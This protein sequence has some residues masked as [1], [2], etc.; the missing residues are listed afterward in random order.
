MYQRMMDEYRKRALSE[1][2][3]KIA[4]QCQPFVREGKL[5]IRKDGERFFFPMFGCG[6][7]EE[8]TKRFFMFTR[9]ERVKF[10]EIRIFA[11]HEQ[12]RI[13]ICHL[14]SFNRKNI[15][16]VR[17]LLLSYKDALVLDTMMFHYFHGWCNLM[18]EV[19]S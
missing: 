19:L 7:F 17:G 15:E 13:L 5:K 2:A 16:T 11:A 6:I 10:A 18:Q 14:F 1:M 3:E 4:E 9:K 8:R 12:G